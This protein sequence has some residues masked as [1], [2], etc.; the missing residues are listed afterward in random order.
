MTNRDPF[1]SVALVR[2]VAGFVIACG[3]G[4]VVRLRKRSARY[5][6]VASGK[7]E[8][9]T[10]YENV[11]QWLTDVSYSYNI[12]GEFY[13]G[14]FQLTSRSERKANEHEFRWKGRNI[15]V[16]Y[17]PRNKNVSVVRIEDQAGLYGEEFKGH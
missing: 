2:D 17:S 11:S 7:V 9:A 15:G 14:Q 8:S 3:T 13:S 1:H 5:W 4:V 10:S 16:R 12:D 6:P